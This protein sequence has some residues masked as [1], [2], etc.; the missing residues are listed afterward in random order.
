MFVPM[1]Q[2]KSN[3][4]EAKEL[5]NSISYLQSQF[6]KNLIDQL[7]TFLSL[8]N[9]HN[10]E[11]F[12]CGVRTMEHFYELK[13][14]NEVQECFKK[15]D[16]DGNGCIDRQELAS[17]SLTLGHSLNEDELTA[18]LEDLDLNHDGTIDFDE[19]CRWYFTGMKAYN[20][21]KKSMLK[22]GQSTTT[23]FEALK[24]EELAKI[25][26]TDQ[27]LTKHK[28]MVKF[29]DGSEDTDSIGGQGAGWGF[30]SQRRPTAMEENFIR[31]N[32]HFLGSETA[33]INQLFQEYKLSAP[34][35]LI[36]RKKEGDMETYLLCNMQVQK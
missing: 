14:E 3:Q 31:F 29:N 4:N 7:P 15:F 28:M 32:G 19:F 11:Q 25:I 33:K 34:Q 13:K 20:G 24:S 36:P 18:A 6:N 5:L 35:E 21:G 26:K 1:P 27:R 23:V 22:I 16:L 17:L 8:D 12:L 2:K 10:A 30:N 9:N